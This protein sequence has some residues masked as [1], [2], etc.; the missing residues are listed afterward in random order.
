MIYR[1]AFAEQVF[2]F[3]IYGLG[4]CL[5]DGMLLSLAVVC[6]GGA[7]YVMRNLRRSR[8]GAFLMATITLALSVRAFAQTSSEVA[9]E[10]PLRFDVVSIRPSG[11]SSRMAVGILPD[12]YEAIAVPLETVLYVAYA[13]APFYKHLEEVKG[14]PSWATTE[15]YDLIAKVAPEDAERWRNLKVNNWHTSV[16]LQSML[17]AVL[18]ERCHLQIHG[19]EGMTDA[20]ALVRRPNAPPLT[21]S[22]ELPTAGTIME[23][24]D[25]AK[26]VFEKREGE[27][28]YTFYNTPMSELAIFIGIPS[29]RLVEDRTGLHG[30][31]K[32]VLHAPDPTSQESEGEQADRPVPYDL[33]AIGMTVENIKV[34]S[35]I[36]TIDRMDRPTPN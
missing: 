26:A 36:W 16:E 7:G 21:E 10:K 13:P 9:T 25:G 27:R 14:F 11:E 32:L 15:K 1:D 4:K 35:T 33:R 18:A 2:A 5:P 31:Y 3:P 28:V 19:E 6:V 17:R 8:V 20:Y 24:T 30:R 12:G 34:H 23:F 22:T 29:K